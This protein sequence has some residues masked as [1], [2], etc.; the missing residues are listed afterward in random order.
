MGQASYSIVAAISRPSWPDRT[1]WRRPNSLLQSFAVRPSSIAR[2]TLGLHDSI[3]RLFLEV[4]RLKVG[5]LW[6]G[7]GT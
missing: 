7:F 2:N 1:P 6:Q 3:C 4:A 5:H